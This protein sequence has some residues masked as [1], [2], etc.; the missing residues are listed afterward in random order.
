MTGPEPDV[1]WFIKAFVWMLGAFSVAL[2]F[3]AYT[4][5]TRHAEMER[6]CLKER[7]AYECYAMLRGRAT[8]IPEPRP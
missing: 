6:Q 2:I 1:P 5:F 4:V 3:V 7:P 8:A